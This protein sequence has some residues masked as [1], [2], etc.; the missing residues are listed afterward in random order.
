MAF[1]AGQRVTAASLSWDTDA[2][3][4]TD[5]TASATGTWEQWG[6]EQIQ[7]PDPGLPVKVRA[8]LTGRFVNTADT[9]SNAAARVLISL[10][11]GGTF[12]AAN[13]PGAN[14]GT[15]V[16]TRATAVAANFVEG[17]PSGDIVVKAEL[18]VSDTSI[19]CQDGYIMAD[20]FP[21]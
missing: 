10:D 14:V 4:L 15:S 12:T 8:W 6:S 1:R 2:T 13:T 20:V 18:L 21:Q 11:G 3:T 7:F 19:S 16:G 17:T 9:D 5:D